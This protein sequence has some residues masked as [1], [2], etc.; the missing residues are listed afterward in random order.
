PAKTPRAV[1]QTLHDAIVEV[2]KDPALQAKIRQ[3]GF[4]PADVGLANFDAYIGNDMRRLG[5]LLA[6]IGK[7][8]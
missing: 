1:L 8:N 3:Q 5:P 6:D 2:G 7:S 4:T